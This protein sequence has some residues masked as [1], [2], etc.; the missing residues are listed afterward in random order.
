MIVENYLKAVPTLADERGG[1]FGRKALNKYLLDGNFTAATSNRIGTEIVRFSNNFIGE[2]SA[3]T[4]FMK[5]FLPL[6]T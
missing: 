3:Y 5:A 6:K 4:G 1:P 2:S